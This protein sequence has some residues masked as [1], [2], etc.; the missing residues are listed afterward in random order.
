MEG[1]GAQGLTQII[2]KMAERLIGQD[3]GR[4]SATAPISIGHRQA[5]GSIQMAIAE[6]ENALIDGESPSGL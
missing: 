1:Y 3:P 4:S 6:I 5:A 2:R